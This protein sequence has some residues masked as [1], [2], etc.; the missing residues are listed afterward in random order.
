MELVYLWVEE[1]KN[2]KN[3]GFNFSPRFKCKYEDG[4]LTIDENKAHVSIFP[5]NINVTAIVGENGS[6]KSTL[7][8]MLLNIFAEGYDKP[9]FDYILVYDDNGS[10][11]CSKNIKFNDI[12]NLIKGYRDFNIYDEGLSNY[13]D[14]VVAVYLNNEVQNIF[15]DKESHSNEQLSKHHIPFLTTRERSLFV[16]ENHMRGKYDFLK[17]KE[18]F[19]ILN[20]IIISF[21]GHD[22][23]PYKSLTNDIEYYDEEGEKHIKDISSKFRDYTFFEKL[24]ELHSLFDFK[25]KNHLAINTLMDLSSKKSASYFRKY[26][27]DDNFLE[28][29][30]NKIQDSDTKLPRF[31]FNIDE[32]DTKLFKFLKLLPEDVFTI[33]LVD[34]NNTFF[35][36][37][38]YGERQLLTQLHLILNSISKLDYKTYHPEQRYEDG[39]IREE[40]Y[41][42]HDIKKVLLFIDEFELGLHPFWQKNVMNYIIGFL[43]EIEKDFNLVLTSHSPFILSDLPK[44]NVIFL[45]KDENGNCKNVTKETNIDTFGANIHTLLSH[46]FFMNGGLMGEFAKEK[47][48]DV[49]STIKKDTL[50]KDEIN[51]CKNIISIIGEPI[52]KKTLEHKLNEK[53]NSNESELERLEREKEEIE[54]KIKKLTGKSNNETN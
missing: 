53:L 33:E 51:T 54:K 43:K 30:P 3:Q 44:E 45:K 23:I 26:K 27:L 21:N 50:S 52:L 34:V 8:K 29:I 19:F 38:S 40:Y 22:Y 35:S 14:D 4:K 12:N 13:H 2:I 31:E 10:L 28:L 47:I 37:L 6:G 48:N 11:S 24:K 18:N 15:T 41:T 49:I 7:L 39:S 16:L 46:G 1:Y 20:K 9:P 17:Y 25:I 32:L 36:Q 5:D 42:K